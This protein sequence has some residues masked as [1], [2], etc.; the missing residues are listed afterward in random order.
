M[1]IPKAKDAI[2]QAIQVVVALL[3]ALKGAQNIWQILGCETLTQFVRNVLQLE[4]VPTVHVFGVNG[5]L[6][7]LWNSMTVSPKVFLR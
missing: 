2:L 4:I 6:Y 5:E 7:R 1:K 3:A